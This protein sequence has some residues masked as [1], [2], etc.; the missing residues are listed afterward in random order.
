MKRKTPKSD[1]YQKVKA[2]FIQYQMPFWEHEKKNLNFVV[3]LWTYCKM[4]LGFGLDKMGSIQFIVSK[5][6]L[7]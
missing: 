3:G 5:R 1:V 7:P 4:S 6:Y 2:K